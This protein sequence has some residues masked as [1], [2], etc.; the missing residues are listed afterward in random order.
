VHE[1]DVVVE[2][3]GGF[4]NLCRLMHRLGFRGRYVIFD[5]APFTHLQRYYLRSAGLLHDGDGRIVLTSDFAELE[6]AVATIAPEE[7]AMFVACWSL[8]E[9]PLSL[10]A[11]VRPVAERIGR[12]CIAYQERYGEV[13]NVDYFTNQWFAGPRRTERLAHRPDDHLLAGDVR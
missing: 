5:L 12:Y 11:K 1:W 10:R 7:W 2:L 3:G 9:T 8:S 6:A 13:D 4:G